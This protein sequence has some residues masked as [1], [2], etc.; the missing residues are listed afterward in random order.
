MTV[1]SSWSVGGGD[2]GRV[3]AQSRPGEGGH[4]GASDE[5]IMRDEDLARH[6]FHQV[7]AYD[8]PTI[9]LY[10]EHGTGI[11]ATVDSWTDSR[12]VKRSGSCPLTST[13][14]NALYH[15]LATRE[16]LADARVSE[17]RDWCASRPASSAR[18]VSVQKGVEQ[19]SSTATRCG[20]GGTR[21]KTRRRSVTS[22]GSVLPD[23]SCPECP[24][25]DV[26]VGEKAADGANVQRWY[27]CPDC[28]WRSPSRIVYGAER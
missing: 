12:R 4:R 3:R 17:H 5:E 11:R 13:S 28:G 10:T 20:R 24:N 8:G 1:R 18:F 23:L 16:P 15:Q 26:R 21:R 19:S 7:G 9:F 22:S 25:E 2:E 6:A 27:D 14:K